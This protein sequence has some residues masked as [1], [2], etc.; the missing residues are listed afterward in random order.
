[1]SLAGSLKQFQ[2]ERADAVTRNIQHARPSSTAPARTSTP[3]P[4]GGEKRKHDA[5]FVPATSTGTAREM[6]T[7]V[8]AAVKYLQERYPK[9]FTWDQ[10]KSY[11]SLPIDVNETNIKQALVGNDRVMSTSERG[12]G[13]ESFKYR[14]LHPVTN[15]EELRRYM[16]TQDTARGVKVK[17]LKDGWPDCAATI[18]RLESEGHIIVTRNNKD[19]TALLVYPDSP[20]YHVTNPIAGSQQVGK[21]DADFQNYWTKIKLPANENDIRSELERAHLTPTSAV[22]ETKKVDTTKKKA[23]RKEKA[24]AKKTNVHMAGVFKD[25]TQLK[26]PGGA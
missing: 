11:L 23:R 18:D 2:S 22:K 26:R 17:E 6:M 16:A 7:Y 4:S 14:P 10:V 1:M 8:I 24:N 15:G 20:S 9:A 12:K 19:K 5:A 25:Y 3:V 21:V 13:R